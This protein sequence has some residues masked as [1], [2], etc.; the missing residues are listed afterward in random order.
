MKWPRV[1]LFLSG[2]GLSAMLAGV[3]Y[4]ARDTHAAPPAGVKAAIFFEEGEDQERFSLAELKEQ[5]KTHKLTLRD[6]LHKKEKNYKA[7]ALHD[8]LRLGFENRWQSDKYSD[9]AFVALDGYQALGALPVLRESGG[10]VVYEDLDRDGWEPIGERKTD[11]AP[12]YLLWTGEAQGPKGVYPW[13]YQLQT[14]RLLKFKDQ[15]PKVY[16]AGVKEGSAVHQGFTLFRQVCFACHAMSRQG[17]TVGPDLNA[18]R[19]ITEY[20]DE[21]MIRDYVRAPSRFRYTK[22]PD[23]PNLTDEELDHLLAYF[24][25]QAEH[26]SDDE[27][28]NP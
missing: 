17:G 15:Y 8:L 21:K 22:M 4:T 9:I 20:R 16:P 12:F 19:N 28:T 25:H 3:V 10:Y 11:P 6:P 5:L 23:N 26:K 1:A 14:I 18:P 27:S 7:F 24:R 2:I 13:P